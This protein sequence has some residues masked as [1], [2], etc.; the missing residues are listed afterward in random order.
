MQLNFIASNWLRQYPFRAGQGTL[1]LYNMVVPTDLL[2]GLRITCSQADL[3]VYVDHITTNTGNISVSISGAQG[4]LGYANGIITDSNQ[5]LS[6]KSYA[7]GTIGL[8]TIGNITSTQE[9]QTFVFNN[10]NGLV[11]PS[12]VTILAPPT[13]SGIQ[14]KGQTVVGNITLTSATVAITA[15]GAIT[16]TVLDPTTITSREDKSSVMLTCDNNVIGGINSIVPSGKNSATPNNIDIYAIAPLQIEYTTINGQS[17]LVLSSTVELSRMCVPLNNP[18]IDDTTISHVPIAEI[19][20][21]EW[22][23]WPQYNS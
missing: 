15:Q 17:A 21:P 5:S 18:P 1:D 8:V 16:L 10:T 11:E 6:I 7:S 3:P 2:V 20:E 19:T 22:Q 13:V 23:S 9:Q 4:P 12:T 14:I